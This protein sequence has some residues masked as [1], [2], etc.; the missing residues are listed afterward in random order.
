[1]NKA[2]ETIII[3]KKKK[4][5]GH[6]HHGGAWKVAFADF[7]TS[8]MAFFLVLWIV[9]QSSDIRAAVAG[10]FQD[11]LGRASEFGSSIIKGDGAQ[12]ANPRP[13]PE[14]QTTDLRKDRLQVLGDRIRK[15]LR[16]QF[17]FRNIAQ[18]IEIELTNEGLRIQLVEDSTG[19]FFESG[20]AVPKPLGVRLLQLLGQELG[21]MPNP[22]VVDG[23]TDAVP[24]TINVGYSNW[25]L[26]ADRANVARRIMVLGGLPSR[27]VQQVRGHADRDL[28]DP[29]N[30]HAA[31]N[32]R[33]TITMLFID[34]ALDEQRD[35]L[36]AKTRRADSL[37]IP[38]PAP[39]SVIPVSGIPAEPVLAPPDST[40]FR[41]HRP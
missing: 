1:V 8:L 16:Q 3:V 18:H 12:A 25:E 23:Y 15:R 10:Y 19:I 39:D 34:D 38:V 37:A 4:V 13:I 36:V 2:R 7:M 20:K 33:V 21:T 22:V 9:T 28:R 35:S 17:E 27:Q 6:A 31:S 32:R 41:V 14:S 24:Y 30:P 26:S 5:H 29:E 40:L 11:P